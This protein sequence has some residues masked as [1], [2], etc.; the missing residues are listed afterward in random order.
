MT[1]EAAST[2]SGLPTIGPEH[3]QRIPCLRPVL[4]GTEGEVLGTLGTAEVG[5]STSFRY[6]GVYAM[7]SARNS[8]R[9]AFAGMFVTATR[10]TRHTASASRRHRKAMSTTRTLFPR[11]GVTTNDLVRTYD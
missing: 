3:T 1:A 8:V 9:S 11:A 6:E 10:C 2:P 4:F 5:H 7:L